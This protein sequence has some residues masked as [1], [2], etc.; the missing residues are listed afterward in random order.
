VYARAREEVN[1]FSC[2]TRGN[3][4]V[5]ARAEQSFGQSPL[6]P[7]VHRPRQAVQKSAQTERA[8]YM[9]GT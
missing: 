6:L 4:G 5:V 8:E 2:A 7:L 1:N 3:I 9:S